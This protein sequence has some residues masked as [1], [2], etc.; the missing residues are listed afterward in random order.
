MLLGVDGVVLEDDVHVV[1]DVGALALGVSDGVA[2]VLGGHELLRVHDGGG[3]QVVHDPVVVVLAVD[4][5]LEISN[6]LVLQVH[7]A[8]H[9]AV[10]LGAHSK[11]KKGQT[12]IIS[13]K[14]NHLISRVLD[15]ITTEEL[16]QIL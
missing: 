9:S 15:S 12:C 6:I 2:H 11:L 16:S 3:W 5:L 1:V 10:L 7:L 8:Q 14:I 13:W 4:G